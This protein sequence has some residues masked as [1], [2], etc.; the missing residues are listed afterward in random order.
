M[1][2]AQIQIRIN[3]IALDTQHEGPAGID[4]V[5]EFMKGI[6]AGRDSIGKMKVHGIVGDLQEVQFISW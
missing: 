5:G 1:N 2:G 4:Q 6:P 3:N